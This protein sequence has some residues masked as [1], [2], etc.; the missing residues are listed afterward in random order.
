MLRDV[1]MVNR[2]RVVMVEIVLVTGA[3]GFIGSH[4]VANLLSKGWCVRAALRAPDDPERVDH[5]LALPVGDGGSLEVVKMDLLDA[6]E[7]NA[8][9]AG[10][11]DVIH[12]AA[13]L[14]VGK[15]DPQ[16]EVIDPSLIGTQN[17]CD[18]IDATNSVKRLVH[19]SSTAAIRP[20]KY[21]DGTCF[22]SESWADD[23]T[24]ENN[25][26]G[27]AKAGAERLVREWHANK[28]ENTRPRLVTIHPCVV[29]GPPLSKRHLGGSLSYVEALYKR[30]MP[31]SLPVHIN[32]VD[33][34]D[35]A[36][37]H[38]RALTEGE[39]CS[40]YLVIGGDMWM[41]EVADILRT[42]YPERKWPKGVLP[43]PVCLIAALFHP[44][45]SIKWAR[46]SLKRHCT[47]DATPA[48]QELNMTFRQPRESIIDS[49]PPIRD[50]NW[51]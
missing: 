20:T 50:N 9:V 10:C 28:D 35:V 36:E 49:I 21:E 26:Y 25:A 16:K 40:R 27:L 18:A 34:R 17:I 24:I 42:A 46:S 48:K 7:V 31:K 43:Y 44:K 32:I 14:Y 19:T 51:A 41:K 33:V 5:L 8:A 4:I 13:A 39:P 45:I 3:S 2:V 37:S 1:F 6:D 22:T 47:F 11:S 15:S 29:F 12:A 30:T 23:A 38:V